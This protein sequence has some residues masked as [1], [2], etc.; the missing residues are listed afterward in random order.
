MNRKYDLICMGRSCIDLYA[1]QVGVPFVD[2]QDFSAYVGG[3]PTNIAV[4]ARRLGLK[5]ALLTAVGDDLVGD[6]VLHYLVSEGVDTQFTPRKPGSRTSAVLVSIE[7]PDKFPLVY[8]REN[9][10]D[11]QLNC[12]DVLGTPIANSQALL[13]AGTNMVRETVRSATLFAAEHARAAGTDVFLDLD[14]RPSLWDDTRQYG[15]A[16][17]SLLPLVNVVVGTEEE[18]RAASDR[19]DVL[20]AV[21]MLHAH[22]PQV[23]VVKRGAHGAAVHLGDGPVIDAPSFPVE[24]MNT[25]GAGDAFASGLIYGYTKDWDWYRAAR[26]GNANGAIVVTRHGCSKF[27]GY[28]QEVLD[29]ITARGGF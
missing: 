19:E 9:A 24:I 15:I 18:L 8:Y 29:F 27:M 12:D 20:G 3:C 17:R 26:M 2:V 25:L 21:Q 10:A 7:P 11:N 28:E 6:F 5:V 14:L 16:M 1:N 13:I 23:V 4:G 22:G